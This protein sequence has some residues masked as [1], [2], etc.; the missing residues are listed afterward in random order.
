[1]RVCVSQSDTAWEAPAEN[2]KRCRELICEAA[3]NGADLIVFPE[4]C[5]T[6]FTM[7]G[8][9]ADTTGET[10]SFFGECSEKYGIACVFGYSRAEGGKLYNRLAAAD[11][12]GALLAEYSKL[13]P[14][15]YSGE[16][17]VYSAGDEVVSADICG[18]KTGLTICYDLRF[19]E[20][21]QRLSRE[22]GCIIVS[23]NWPEQRRAH[24]NT[25]LHA[26]AI[27]NQCYIIGCNRCKE[28]GGLLYS[29]DSAVYAPDGELLCAAPPYE[30]ALIYADV[31][32]EEVKSVQRG[33]PLKK[34]RR[35]DIYRN[36][37]E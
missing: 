16:G 25:L 7:K 36:F 19:P 29:G 32:A 17:D 23:A 26:R 10:V 1:M 14:F 28:G 30:R 21:Y 6:G 5:L 27:E 37:Y 13:H 9:L 22:C 33:F 11:K 2:M 15:S 31:S 4:M 18:I 35:N 24:W 20:L 3:R 34:D 12:N 8:E